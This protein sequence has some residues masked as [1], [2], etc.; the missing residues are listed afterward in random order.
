[1]VD[2]APKIVLDA[3]DLYKHLIQVPLPL[4]VLT[5]IGG[6]FRPD[7]TRE[8]RTKVIDPSPDALMANIDTAFMQQVLNIAKRESGNR[9]Y[10]ITA[11][12]MI[13][14]DV[15]KYRLGVSVVRRR[16][17]TISLLSGVSPRIVGTK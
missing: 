17:E 12:G 9:T 7:L 1:M 4:R 2:S 15:L 16:I 5:H 3:I 14:G 13:S 10:N 6:S 8:D 11:S